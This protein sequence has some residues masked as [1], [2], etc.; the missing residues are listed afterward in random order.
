[1]VTWSAPEDNGSEITAYRIVLIDSTSEYLTELTQCDGS[2]AT[3]VNG[4]SCTIHLST[5]TS[6]PFLLKL[7][8][9]ILAKVSALNVYGEGEI[10]A[11]GGGAVIV[12]VPDAPD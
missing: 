4:L 12:L 9:N 10:S 3:I 7:G 8:D 6:S 2:L 11:P 5:L 1:V